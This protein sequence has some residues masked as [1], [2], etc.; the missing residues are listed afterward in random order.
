[1]NQLGLFDYEPPTTR[2]TNARITS[3]AA[4]VAM[5]PHLG[6]IRRKILGHLVAVGDVGATDGE[7][8]E[9]LGLR[10]STE[11]GRRKELEDGGFVVDSGLIRL[12]QSKRAAVVWRATSKATI[13]APKQPAFPEQPTTQTPRGK[14]G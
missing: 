13:D 11:R 8:Q 7:I 6:T 5:L 4:G 2:S 1:M 10:G 14:G 12:T 9:A 3:R